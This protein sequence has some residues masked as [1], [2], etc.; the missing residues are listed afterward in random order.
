MSEPPPSPKTSLAPGPSLKAHAAVDEKIEKIA[1]EPTLKIIEATK[2]PASLEVVGGDDDDKGAKV[3]LGEKAG[4][5]TDNP[6]ALKAVMDAKEKIDRDLVK[7]TESATD[8]WEQFWERLFNRLMEGRFNLFQIT[9]DHQNKIIKFLGGGFPGML[10]EKIAPYVKKLSEKKSGH[11]PAEG[12]AEKTD[13]NANHGVPSVNAANTVD[14]KL[15]EQLHEA[16][17]TYAEG[18]QS[19]GVGNNNPSGTFTP[20]YTNGSAASQSTG[21]PPPKQPESKEPA[22]SPTTPKIPKA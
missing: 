12:D 14:P 3:G 13:P 5:E 22:T 4:D 2:P 6:E 17:H 19:G 18:K 8:P 10:A 11:T 7:L 21:V 16:A 9:R 20:G 15:A 1:D